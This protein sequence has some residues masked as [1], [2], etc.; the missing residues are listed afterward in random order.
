MGIHVNTQQQAESALDTFIK[1]WGRMGVQ[2][3]VGR[4]MAEIQALLYL[5]GRPLGLDEMADR[6]KTSRSNV[7]LNVRILQDLGVVRKVHVPGDRKN[8]YRAEADLQ[9]VAR[10]LAS[11]KKKR[12][13]DPAIS[14]VKRTIE[15]ADALQ[16]ESNEENDP[17]AVDAE[18]LRELKAL[19]EKIGDIFDAF[20]DFERSASLGAAKT[21]Q[22]R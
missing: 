17:R 22:Q 2:W 18:R 13:I 5:S 12:E 21:D 19:L 14:V 11:A 8:Y 1:G 4:M 10:R 6:L 7:S 15:A 20:I 9:L 16:W 3:G